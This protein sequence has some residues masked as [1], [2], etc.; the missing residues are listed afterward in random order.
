MQEATTTEIGE[1]TEAVGRPAFQPSKLTRIVRA[2]HRDVGFLLV[3]FTMVCCL[4]G[5]LL[6]YKNQGLLQYEQTTE[7][8]IAPGLAGEDLGRALAGAISR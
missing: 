7:S 1:R 6:I 3:G 8:T 5:I 2:L 4:S